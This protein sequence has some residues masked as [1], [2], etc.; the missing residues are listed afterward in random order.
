MRSCLRRPRPPR[1]RRP[2]VA[3]EVVATAGVGTAVGVDTAAVAG[4]TVVAGE[5]TEVVTVAVPAERRP[6]GQARGSGSRRGERKTA[7][8]G[9]GR[10]ASSS[11][12]KETAMAAVKPRDDT[13]TTSSPRQ[14]VRVEVAPPL[15]G[16][17]T[18]V[19]AAEVRSTRAV[20]A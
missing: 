5:A 1:P 15:D 6:S 19:R 8:V 9:R 18:T 20:V 4:D 13:R 17:R 12:S 3:V 7:Q 11:G 16:Q 10:V 14:T 2:P